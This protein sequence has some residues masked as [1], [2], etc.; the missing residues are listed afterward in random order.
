MPADATLHLQSL[1]DKKIIKFKI[2]KVI[3]NIIFVI[4]AQE[5]L[6]PGECS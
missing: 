6:K 2:I 4:F 3:F 1:A 5:C